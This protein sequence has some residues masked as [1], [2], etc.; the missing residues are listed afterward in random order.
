MD[1]QFWQQA[2]AAGRIGFHRA[3]PHAFLKKYVERLGVGAPRGALPVLVPLCGKSTDLALLTGQ[4]FAVTGIELVRS[5]ADQFFAEHGLS[6]VEEPWNGYRSLRAAGIRIAVGNFF[7]LR[8][9]DGERFGAAYDRAALVAM[10]P[11]DR[12]RYV[13]TLLGALE[14]GA[15]LL[16]VTFDYEGAGMTGPPFSVPEAEVRRLFASCA[17]ELLE[18]ADI[19]DSEPRFRERGATSIA[20]QAWLVTVPGPK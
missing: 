7:Q 12:D 18:T 6:T 20:E 10:T 2:W 1:E 14:P 19:T 13:A 11:E 9:P 3:E 4:G 16:L 8:L 15:R 17:L 5:A